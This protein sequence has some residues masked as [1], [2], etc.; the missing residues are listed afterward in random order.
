MNVSDKQTKAL[1]ELAKLITKISLR[2]EEVYLGWKRKNI[3]IKV[4]KTP[5]GILDK[6]IYFKFLE[7]FLNQGA[8]VYRKLNVK[9]VT[10]KK[11]M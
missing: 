4:E 1:F 9:E 7:V 2:A 8:N 6:S 5:W 10:E 11:T 3:S